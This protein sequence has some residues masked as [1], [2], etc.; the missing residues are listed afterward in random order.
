MSKQ[1]E[2]K[3]AAQTGRSHRRVRPCPVCGRPA[4]A[5][6]HPFCSQRCRDVDLGR[7]LKG[8]Y[9]IPGRAP[10]LGEEDDDP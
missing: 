8:S 5:V 7:W 3:P 10:G 2:S 1:S 6:Q 9:H 4:V